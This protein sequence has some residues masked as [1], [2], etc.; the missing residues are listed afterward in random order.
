MKSAFYLCVCLSAGALFADEVKLR[1]GTV[2]EGTILAENPDS[3]E[4]EIGSNESGTIHRILRIHAS[5]ISS[6]SSDKPRAGGEEGSGGMIPDSGAVHVDRM[7][8][9]AEARMRDR[10]LEEGIAGFAQAAEAAVSNLDQLDPGQKA[11]A[12]KL[13]AHALRLQL[14]AME[15][16]VAML[17]RQTEGVQD[18]LDERTRALERAE[19]RLQSDMADFNSDQQSRGVDIRTRRTQNELAERKEELKRRRAEL[20][21]EQASVGYRIRELEAEKIR[22]ETQMV[23]VEER[24]DRVEDDAKAAERSARG[25]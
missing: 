3:I 24:V 9:E 7:L 5:E 23:L 25:R 2:I 10:R 11:E 18:E 21:R 14:A 6:W 19:A 20:N 8:R 13:R 12:L 16:K 17:E 1:D 4:I 22:T 15:G